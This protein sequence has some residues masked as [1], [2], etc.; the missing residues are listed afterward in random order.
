M[1][2]RRSGDKGGNGRGGGG[3]RRRSAG[4]GQ[5]ELDLQPTEAVDASLADETRRR[6]LNYA[7]SVITSRALPDVR[8]GL[9]PV[10][11]RILYVMWALM[12]LRHDVK[13][14][15]SATVVGEVMGKLHPHGDSAIYEAMVRLAQAWVMRVPLVDG[16]GNFGSP[17]GDAPAA[18]RYTEA[19]L[20]AVAAELM[21]ELGARTV[22]FR[23]NYDGQSF[24]PVVLPARFPHLLVNGSQGIA[25]GMA[26]SIPPHDLGEVLRAAIA[27]VDDPDLSVRQLLRIIKGPDFP[28]GGELLAS[29][30]ELARVYETGQGTWKLRGEWTLEAADHARGNPRIV[31]TSIPYAVERR[32]VV[33][34]IAEVIVGKK[35]PPLLDVRDESTDDTRVVCEIRRDADPQLV[36]A[37]LFKHTPLQTTVAVNLTCLVPTEPPRLDDEE[38]GDPTGAGEPDAPETVVGAPAAPRRLSLRDMLDHFL[39]FRMEVVVRRTRHEL[40]ELRKR[41]HILEGFVVVFDALDEVIRIIRRS[42]GRADARA[43]L[44]KRFDLDEVQTDAILDLRLY[45][46]A[47]LEILVIRQ[48]L[49]EKRKEARKKERLLK[50]EKARWTLIRGELEEVAKA[51]PSTRRSKVLSEVDEPAFD[52]EDFIVEEDAMVLVTQQGWV[53][54]QQRIRDIGATR[55]REGDAVLGVVAGSTRSSVAFFS[56]V[57]SCYVARLVDVP[58]TTGYGVPVQT[59]FK[60]ADGERIVRVLSFDPRFLD[61]P[62]P[63]EGAEVIEGPYALAVTRRGL[64]MQFSLRGHREPSTKSGRRYMRVAD[65]DDVVLLDLVEEGDRVGCVTEQ[66]RALVC[67]E[68]DVPLL[69][70]PGKGVMLI[71]LAK[72][73]AVLGAAVLRRDSDA[74]AAERESGVEVT[75]TTRKYEPTSRAG[76]GFPLIKRGRLSR[77]VPPEVEV[78]AFPEDR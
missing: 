54:R 19:R 55:V 27:L 7:L 71:K 35:L 2:G 12:R 78:P 68:G 51:Y 63:T 5:S 75:V 45:R 34:K 26:T 48:E 6:Y 37:Y 41:I 53:K 13:Y 42:D 25:V 43:K 30:D 70:G 67:D 60:L 50:S 61:V 76:K 39:D 77:V 33:E 36:M 49:D 29:R 24:E 44:M 15:K 9:K 62:P 22:D 20:E 32:A 38:P 23:P 21:S 57:G 52:A 65:G 40:A 59:L 16:R 31:I 17:D 58:A 73:D 69:S 18:M 74:L 3:R 28:T 56:N 64:T 11:R 4:R 8:D 47:K 66:G 72:G 14:R 1:A 46:L 10:Q